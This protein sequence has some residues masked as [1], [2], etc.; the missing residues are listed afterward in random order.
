MDSTPI[1]WWYVAAGQ[2]LGPVDTDELRRLY[3]AG[4]IGDETAVWTQGMAWG[5]I[6]EVPALADFRHAIPADLPPPLPTAFSD[7]EPGGATVSAPAPR[8]ASLSR[9]EQARDKLAALPPAGPWRRFFARLIDVTLLSLPCGFAVAFVGAR[10]SL[11]FALWVQQPGTTYIFGALV[12]PLLL[13]VEAA[14]YGVF[15]TTPG[16]ALLAVRVMTIG[17]RQPTFREYLQRQFQVWWLGMAAGIPLVN[18]FTMSIQYSK[19]SKGEVTAWDEGRFSVKGTPALGFV[20]GALATLA[21]VCVYALNGYVQNMDREQLRAKEWINP[22]THRSADLPAGWI[23]EQSKNTLG[24]SYYTFTQPR[25]GLIVVFAAEGAG[26]LSVR[27]YGPLWSRAVRQDIAIVRGD[28]V[29]DGNEVVWL[30][31]GT[32]RANGAKVHVRVVARDGLMWRTLVIHTAQAKLED[33]EPLQ[34]ALANTIKHTY[35]DLSHV[36]LGPTT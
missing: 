23:H 25:Q 19:L 5:P 6:R 18:L 31:Q 20:R 9:E 27:D 32:L 7:T 34:R 11:E 33:A 12:L 36:D 4:D 16:K 15:G 10:L 13:L 3:L 29:D 24:H 28:A 17:L 21:V 1:A 35:K 22:T 8:E 2:R 26:A 30:G 14:I